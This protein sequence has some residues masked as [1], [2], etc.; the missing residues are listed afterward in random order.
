MSIEREVVSRA[1]PP[2]ASMSS[3]CLVFLL[4][5]FIPVPLNT[6]ARVEDS[7]AGEEVVIRDGTGSG[8]SNL[9]TGEYPVIPPPR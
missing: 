2:I 6:G 9:G 4:P 3:A 5:S 1:S 8:V 7:G